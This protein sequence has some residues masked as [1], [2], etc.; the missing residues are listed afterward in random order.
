M[1][2]SDQSVRGS[3]VSRQVRHT[4]SH[5]SD[6]STGIGVPHILLRVF[7]R[8]YLLSDKCFVVWSFRTTFVR[9]D[10]YFSDHSGRLS[11]SFGASLSPGV[12]VDPSGVGLRRS[13]P[14]GRDRRLG[15]LP[16]TVTRNERVMFRVTVVLTPQT[17]GEIHRQSPQTCSR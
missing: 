8:V 6:S 1:E 10:K 3:L 5:T 15:D 7:S 17:S 11:T 13:F 14:C 4:P 9:D 16:S 2:G 12:R